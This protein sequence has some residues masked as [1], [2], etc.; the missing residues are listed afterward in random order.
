[1]TAPTFELL[2]PQQVADLLQVTTDTLEGWRAKRI[3]PAWVKLGDGL[4]SPVRYYR[5]D[6]NDYL[7]SRKA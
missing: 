2:T 6:I 1:L 5:Q 7:E 4:R 3:G